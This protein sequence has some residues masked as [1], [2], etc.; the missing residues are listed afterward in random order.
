MNKTRKRK[1]IILIDKPKEKT[2]PEITE[3]ISKLLKTK[4]GHCGSLDP[5]ATGL[6]PITIG[7][8][9]KIQEYI[10]RKDKKYLVEIKTNKEVKKEKMKKALK[11]FQGKI[12]QIPPEKSAVKREKRKRKIYSIKHLNKKNN[13]HTFSVKCQHGTYIRTLV[14]DLSKEIKTETNLEEL[15]RTEIGKWKEKDAF[16]LEEIKK[17]IE[18]RKLEKALIN[19]KNALNEMPEIEIKK[20]AL[21]SISHGED[22][23]SPG[24]KKIKGK[25]G[26]EK[27]VLLTQNGKSVAIGKSLKK[28]NRTE[29]K[30]KGKIVKTKKVLI[31]P[32]K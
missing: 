3:K 20:T 8:A 28:I 5:Y 17:L 27:Q 26:K 32:K 9:V 23:K 15:R 1:G 19:L 30:E 14:K 2:S 24:I 31:E 11:K 12:E 18:E 21:K 4:T 7:K 10:Q 25:I 16:K 29:K 6:L 22:L 13:T